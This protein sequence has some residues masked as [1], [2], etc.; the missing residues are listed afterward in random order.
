[1]TVWRW[2]TRFFRRS[3]ST[4]AYVWM[5]KTIANWPAKARRPTRQP[6]VP[7]NCMY[8]KANL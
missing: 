5:T 6:H 8:E 4:N 2:E 7:R 3:V 1:M